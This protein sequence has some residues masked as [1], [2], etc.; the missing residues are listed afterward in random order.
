MEWAAG[1][2]AARSVYNGFGSDARRD[3]RQP[4]GQLVVGQTA[5]QFAA[6]EPDGFEPGTVNH[7]GAQDGRVGQVPS[8]DLEFGAAFEGQRQGHADPGGR[9]TEGDRP[10]AVGGLNAGRPDETALQNAV[11]G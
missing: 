10:P 3:R 4:S 7:A 6:G 9:Q 2:P 11:P 1:S 8:L 5:D